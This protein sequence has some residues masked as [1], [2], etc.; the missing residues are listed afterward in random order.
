MI[1]NVLIP[2]KIGSY[3][4]FPQRVLGFEITKTQI[5]A[6]QINVSGNLNTTI[7]RYVEESISSNNEY[8]DSATTAIKNI[9]T[10]VDKYNSVRIALPSY[11]V[12]FK[13]LTFPFT[14]LHKIRTI[15]DF[16]IE[17][18]LPYPIEE[19]IADFIVTKQDQK[20]KMTTIFV[21]IARKKDIEDLIQPFKLAGIQPS[22]VTVDVN[23]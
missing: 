2:E 12:I 20:T 18:S 4:L 13:E 19:A 5:N 16:E 23:Q 3:Y 6:T 22:A 21:A 8:I 15:L 11:F 17:P 10:K 9:L 7:E 14:D 1:K